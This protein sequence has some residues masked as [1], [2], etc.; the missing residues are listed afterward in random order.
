MRA[1][2]A[3]PGGRL[4]AHNAHLILPRALPADDSGPRAFLKWTAEPVPLTPG[5]RLGSYD[6]VAPLA[7]SGLQVSTPGESPRGR[8]LDAWRQSSDIARDISS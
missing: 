6:I 8:R 5:I 4:D 7:F 3:L 2:R 1:P